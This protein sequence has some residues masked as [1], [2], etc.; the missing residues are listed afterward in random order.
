[1][2]ASE[3]DVDDTTHPVAKPN[4]SADLLHCATC[5]VGGS[6]L[7]LCACSR[8]FELIHCMTCGTALTK[9]KVAHSSDYEQRSQCARCRNILLSSKTSAQERLVNLVERLIV[10]INTGNEDLVVA[11]TPSIA[12]EAIAAQVSPRFMLQ[13][14]RNYVLHGKGSGSFSDRLFDFLRHEVAMQSRANS[15]PP[16]NKCA[17]K[18]QFECDPPRWPGLPIRMGDNDIGRVTNTRN[19]GAARRVELIRMDVDDLLS[20]RETAAA[21][22]RG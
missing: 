10:A 11:L 20:E 2:A 18:R 7:L 13:T 6:D 17:V 8:H 19:K 1:L 16:P 4:G 5:G 9:R 3:P 21:E 15:G 22:L 14:C 12:T